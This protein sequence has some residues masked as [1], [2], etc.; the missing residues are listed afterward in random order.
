MRRFDALGR[1]K[2]VIG[3]VHLLPLPG[4]PFFELGNTE[5]ALDKAVRDATALSQGG[6]DGCLIQTVDR[7][8]PTGDEADYARVAAVAAITRAVA[9]ATPPDFQIGVQIMVNAL[10][11]SAAVATVCGGSFL[12]C[13]ALVGATVTPSGIVEANPLDFLTYRARIGGDRLKLIAEV[14]SMHF[15]WMG[16]R[17]TADVARTAARM[18]ADAVEVAHPDEAVNNRLVRDIKQR[19]SHTCPSSSAATPTTTT[20]PAASPKPTAPLSA[21]ASNLAAWDSD[22]D[23]E[24]VREYVEIVAN[25]S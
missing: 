2:V 18:G 1:K 24:R 6:T 10:K 17:P 12:R 9:E 16:D 13:T 22:I 5:R 23:V 25:L 15:H 4:T 7:V 11:A 19:P 3:L 8:Y 20:P 14:D 21:R